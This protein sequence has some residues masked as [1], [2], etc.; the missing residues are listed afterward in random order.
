[1][2]ERFEVNAYWWTPCLIAIVIVQMFTL[3]CIIQVYRWAHHQTISQ[4]Y[5][6]A[7]IH[8]PPMGFPLDRL[9]ISAASEISSPSRPILV[10]VFGSCEGCG[11][12]MVQ[13]WASTLSWKTWQKEFTS[14]L[15]FRE[16]AEKVREAARKGRWQVKAVA[17]ES[18]Q[19]ASTLNAFF[20]PRAYGFVDGKLV[21]LQ[22]EPK[23]S[24]VE[25]L[26]SFLKAVKGEDAVSK[27]MDAWAHEMR[28]KAWGK[29][30]AELA[31]SGRR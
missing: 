21:W 23:R 15:V 24:V 31:R 5:K 18:G 12:G 16:R 25:T 1:M 10:V 14:I 28:E 19:I 17:D 13:E 26:E 3:F 22:K 4:I 30:M 7:V 8:D 9:D 6:E 29:E 2:M 27:V 20:A 11:E